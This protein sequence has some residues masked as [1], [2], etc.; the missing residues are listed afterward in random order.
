M[1]KE[2]IEKLEAQI[3]RLH[4]EET[5]LSARLRQIGE[6]KQRVYNQIVELKKAKDEEPE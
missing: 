5:G 1:S 2:E 6:E 4:L 3:G